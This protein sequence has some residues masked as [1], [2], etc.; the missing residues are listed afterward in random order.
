MLLLF[1]YL[2]INEHINLQEAITLIYYGFHKN[3]TRIIL[4]QLDKV[5]SCNEIKTL[6]SP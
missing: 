6:Y 1:L 2:E 5:S 4:K 3:I